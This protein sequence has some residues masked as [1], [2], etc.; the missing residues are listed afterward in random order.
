MG[1]KVAG[2][3]FPRVDTYGTYHLYHTVCTGLLMASPTMATAT[4]SADGDKGQHSNVS[5]MA[6]HVEDSGI[7]D[8]SVPDSHTTDA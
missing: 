4:T 1:P 2:T 5:D 7:D 6:I 3:P 8:W